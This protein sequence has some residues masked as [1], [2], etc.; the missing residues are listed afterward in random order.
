MDIN[1][2]NWDIKDYNWTRSDKQRSDK[3]RSD[4]DTQKSKPILA[5][6]NY[7]TDV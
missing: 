4:K 7:N 2:Y 5:H 1:E 6:Q 3:Q